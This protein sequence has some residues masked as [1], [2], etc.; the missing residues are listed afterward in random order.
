MKFNSGEIVALS[1]TV[2]SAQRTLDTHT[3]NELGVVIRQSQFN[4]NMLELYIRGKILD[5]W[6]FD[7]YQPW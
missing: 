6:P 2:V 4:D 7:L 1:G 3:F 5:V